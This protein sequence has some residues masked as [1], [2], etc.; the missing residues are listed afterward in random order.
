MSSSYLLKQE[1]DA[2]ER[3]QEFAVLYMG[4]SQKQNAPYVNYSK[5]M[6]NNLIDL[7]TFAQKD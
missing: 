1:T 2:T 7:E 3:I 5:K 6:L 4:L